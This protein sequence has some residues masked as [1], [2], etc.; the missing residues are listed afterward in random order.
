MLNHKPETLH[1]NPKP[2]FSVLG[3][4]TEAVLPQPQAHEASAE[5]PLKKLRE[6]RV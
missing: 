3:L 5:D 2:I 6:H 1:L 4:L